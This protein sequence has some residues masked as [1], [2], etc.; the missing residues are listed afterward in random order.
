LNMS[1]AGD[2]SS[3]VTLGRSFSYHIY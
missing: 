3:W 1:L 2:Q